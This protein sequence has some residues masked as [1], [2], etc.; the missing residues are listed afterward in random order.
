MNEIPA[1]LRDVLKHTGNDDKG[2]E[3]RLCDAVA[4]AQEWKRRY[5]LEVE[6]G[7]LKVLEIERVHAEM[8]RIREKE[9]TATASADEWFDKSNA[10]EKQLQ[11]VKLELVNVKR[12]LESTELASNEKDEAI[13][14]LEDELERVENLKQPVWRQY[15]PNVIPEGMFCFKKLDNG[16]IEI[17]SGVSE[18]LW[19][20]A[21]NVIAWFPLPPLNDS[22]K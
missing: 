16:E 9:A 3:Q 4:T 18:F 21:S 10:L 19:K 20:H 22:T 6:T 5:G 15:D 17:A 14:G 2:L 1:W 8:N 13:K 11:D 7:V 12:E